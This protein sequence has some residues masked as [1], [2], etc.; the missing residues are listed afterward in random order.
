MCRGPAATP[1]SGREARDGRGA[2]EQAILPSHKGG[3]RRKSWTTERKCHTCNPE[4]TGRPLA[5]PLR[6][7]SKCDF[8]LERSEA[9]RGRVGRVS[10]ASYIA[11]NII[12]PLKRM[13]R[14]LKNDPQCLPYVARRYEEVAELR[15]AGS[16]FCHI[17]KQTKLI[18][19]YI[20][21]KIHKDVPQL[22]PR[23]QG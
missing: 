10:G 17:N 15:L 21:K 2:G 8:R 23:A 4:S 19:R 16:C 13:H 9:Y 1:L 12:W 11:Q 7:P 18:N 5:S 22:C 3:T 20:R 14:K 6:P